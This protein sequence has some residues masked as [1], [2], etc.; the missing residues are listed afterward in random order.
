MCFNPNALRVLCHDKIVE[1]VRRAMCQDG[2]HPQR[3]RSSPCCCPAPA[4]AYPVPKPV[5]TF[6]LCSTTSFKSDV[7][8]IYPGVAPTVGLLRPP[9]GPLLLCGTP[10]S[11]PSIGSTIG[12][13]PLHTPICGD[14]R[15]P[16]QAHDEPAL[17]NQEPGHL[18]WGR[19][20]GL[21]Q[22][23]IRLWH[24]PRAQRL[25]LQDQCSS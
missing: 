3:R 20:G 11:G 19:G 5:G 15:R 8:V 2:S 14:I 21:H 9:Q 18:A 25:P 7:S 16:G 10:R 4:L 23:A 1:V 12:G 22:G 17:G 6:C 24:P 13:I